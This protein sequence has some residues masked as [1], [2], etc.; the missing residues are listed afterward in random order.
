MNMGKTSTALAGADCAVDDDERIDLWRR[1]IVNQ[2]LSV[3]L[4]ANTV[5][6]LEFLKAHDIDP[7]V[8]ERVLLEPQRRRG[9]RHH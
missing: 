9:L 8:I 5:S 6:A 2:G 4:S 1:D 7:Q 3:Q